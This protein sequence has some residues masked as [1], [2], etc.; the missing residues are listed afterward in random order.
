MFTWK[1]YTFSHKC[2]VFYDKNMKGN[3]DFDLFILIETKL[4]VALNM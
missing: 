3:L 1:S 4:Y 2:F